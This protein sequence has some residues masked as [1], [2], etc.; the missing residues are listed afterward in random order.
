M[1]VYRRIR[2]LREEDL[3]LLKIEEI[4]IEDRIS[5]I[6]TF[7]SSHRHEKIPFEHLFDDG[8]KQMFVVSFFAILCLANTKQISIIQDSHFDE[9]YVEVL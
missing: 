3:L 7:L 1:F 6:H 5:E 8:D 2:D 9:I 4:S